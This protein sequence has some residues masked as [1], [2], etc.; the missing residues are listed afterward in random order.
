M[1]VANF[2]KYKSVQPFDA[3]ELPALTVITGLNGSGKSQFLNGL[4]LQNIRCDLFG[5]LYPPVQI[6]EFAQ[7]Q[8][9]ATPT[10]HPQITLLSN[11]TA[12]PFEFNAQQGSK[13]G[14]RFS[15]RGMGTG[16][17][18]FEAL[19]AQ[20]LFDLRNRLD[21]ELGAT[22]AASFTGSDDPWRIGISK[23][24]RRASEAS[25]DVKW[26]VVALIFSEAETKVEEGFK[27]NSSTNAVGGAMEQA[28][29]EDGISPLTFTQDLASAIS[30]RVP[31]KMF[32]PNIVQTISAYR[33]RLADNDLDEMQSRRDPTKRFFTSEEFL[34][35]YG[36]PPW[37]T[38][39]ELLALMGLPFEVIPPSHEMAQPVNFRLRLIG[40]GPEL[41]FEDISSGERVLLQFALS[42][43]RPSPAMVGL[44][45]P[46]LLLLD[47]MDASLHP[48]M[49]Q[50]W[51]S[52]IERGIVNGFG[53]HVILT[54]HSPTTVALAPEG[55]LLAMVDGRPVR[56]SKQEAINKLTF[57][58]PTLSIDYSGR[59]QVFCESDTDAAAYE[60][61]YA[62]VKPRLTLQ[63][64]LNFIGTGV[65]DKSNVIKTGPGVEINAGEAVVREIV[66]N[67]ANHQVAS[68]F[69]LIDW[70]ARA[71]PT[72]R[73]FV[74][75]RGTYY[76][77]EN[78]LLDP[79][80]IGALMILDRMPIPGL[81]IAPRGLDGLDS[82]ALQEVA[83]AIQT[84]VLLPDDD[85]EMIDVSYLGG[86]NIKVKKRYA[87]ING[88]ELEAEIT[89]T[90]GC[91]RRHTANRGAL[92]KRISEIVITDYPEFCPVAI[93]TTFLGISR[94][95][96]S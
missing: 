15:H 70:D 28:R 37:E 59:R 69:G 72:D 85:G 58:V 57:G 74:M 20:M 50:R 75:G 53:I 66:A 35:L 7:H 40:G 17:S 73:V 11:W 41:S 65:R 43:V 87:S 55:S 48:E 4:L 36:P 9:S 95:K 34:K 13:L 82:L 6:N 8:R 38:M 22:V 25:A 77:L 27:Q 16:A 10:V 94:T 47:E 26:D 61:I 46:L 63:K 45:R 67:L 71:N 64:E 96:L 60:T 54:T 86:A 21:K 24:M 78:I 84:S 14:E 80:L 39:S 49:V 31:A 56:I 18:N 29:K 79:L 89:K 91:L 3:I 83:D 30:S 44:H 90:F 32:E 52:A 2:E 68:V 81:K 19:R 93:T 12:A 51:L 1:L 42:V 76:T 92:T 88:H 23:L 33:D 62:A 5:P